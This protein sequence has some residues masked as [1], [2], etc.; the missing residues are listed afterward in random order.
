MARFHRLLRINLTRRETRIEEIPGEVELRFLGGKGIGTYYFFKEVPPG[1]DPLGPENKF[2]IATGPLNAT[3]APASSRYEIVTK[4]PLTGIYLDCNSGGHFAQEIKATGFDL[5]ILEGVS[6]A[7]VVIYIR[8]EKVGFIDARD[9]WGM[10]IYETETHVRNMLGD[11]GIRV[12]SIGPAGENL[13]RFAS[14]SNDYSRQAAR[15]GSGAVLGSKR[16]KA[17]AVRGTKDIPVRDL[18]AFTRVVERAREVIFNNPWVSDQR[19][20]GTPRSVI[21]VNDAG[22]L[23]VN[24]FTGGHLDD[25]SSIDQYAMDKLVVQRLSCGEC[26][27]ACAKGYRRG[28]IGME[29]PEYE[30]IGLFGPNIG[31]MDPHEIAEYNYYCNQYGMDTITA[32]TL[33][34]A[35]LFSGVVGEELGREDG[36]GSVSGGKG[37]GNDRESRRRIVL[38]LL[39]KITY[40]EGIGG[41]LAEGLKRVGDEFGISYHIPQ[42]KGLGFPAYDPRVSEGTALV[43][44]TAD[45]GACHLRSWP[46]G[47]ELSGILPADD[48]RKKV[49]FVVN[50]QNDKAAEESLIV[51]QFPYGIG[52]LDDVLAELVNEATGEDWDLKKM[53]EVGER[54]WNISRLFNIREGITRK[55]DY[56][57]EKFS[58]EGLGS[59]PLKGKL[60]DRE[61]QDR[62]LDLYYELR[63][64]SRDGVPQESTLRRLGI[65]N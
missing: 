8:D 51:C 38:E 22:F 39:G 6:E 12:M 46:I 63:G 17:I 41:I 27:V 60:I 34:G 11:P 48:L 3:T 9:I 40:R 50:Q 56:L 54:I 36:A 30:T 15:G 59:G 16:V 62:M 42:V 25:V 65:S 1:I 31:V 45:R 19:N 55:D 57:P 21:P 28:N 4:S 33:I 29:G 10:Y 2:I 58:K 52:L 24:N 14:V 18:R 26:P 37:K 64:W 61:V 20:Y 44:M 47:R 53:R 23:P 43:Y 13:V 5:F 32:G 7:P 49:E 35:L